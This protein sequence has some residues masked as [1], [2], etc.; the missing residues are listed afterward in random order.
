MEKIRLYP[1]TRGKTFNKIGK[2]MA[3]L[4]ILASFI[5]LIVELRDGFNTGFPGG[6]WSPVI[7]L[8]LGTLLLFQFRG[9]KNLVDSFIQWDRQTIEYRMFNEKEVTRIS[10][11]DIKEIDIGLTD[12]TIKLPAETK[13]LKLNHVEYKKLMQ[14]KEFFE[15]INLRVEG[16]NAGE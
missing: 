10:I 9:M 11:S 12:I 6:S 13:L 1:F 14:I 8:V 4:I 7:N 5:G 16:I 15:E 3:V 2:W